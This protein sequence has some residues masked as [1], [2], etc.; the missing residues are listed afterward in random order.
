MS[1]NIRIRTNPD[2]SDSFVKLQLNQDFDF[3]EILSLKISQEDIYRSFY[4]DYGVVVGRVIMNSG[5]GVPNARISVFIPL[6]DEDAEDPELSSLYPYSDLQD[7]NS[8]GVR[9]N[10]LP[11]DSQGVCHAPIG[12]FPTKRELIDNDP[13]LEMYDKYFKYTTTTNGAGDFMLF[14]VPVGNHMINIDVDLSDIGIFSQRPY[15]FI[16]E[17]NPKKLFDSPTKFKTGTNLNNLTQ[18]K[19][20]Q[21]GVNVIPFWGDK[22]SNEIGISRIDVDLNY[23][24]NPKAIFMGS[25]FGDNEKNSV[26]KN[27]RPRKKTGKVCEMGQGEGSIQMLRKTIFGDNERYDVEGGRVIT[28][29]GTWAYQIPMNLDYMVTDEFGNLTPTDDPTKGIP[30]RSR[31]RFKINM[32]ST[33]GEGRLRTRAKYLVPHNPE[34]PDE[35]DYSFDDSTSDIQFRDLHWNKIYTVRNHIA[36]FQKD[37]RYEN[38]NFI[39]FKDVDDCVGDKNPIPFSKM[40]TDFNPVYT[41]LCLILSIILS[42]MSIVNKILKVEILSRRICRILVVNCLSITCP[43]NGFEYSPGCHSECGG[44]GNNNYQNAIDCFKIALASA[45]NVFEFDFYNDWINGSLYSFLFKYKKPKNSDPK[46]CGDGNGDTNN[47]IINTNPPNPDP[48]D[49]SPNSTIETSQEFQIDEGVIVSYEEELFYK[50]FSNSYNKLYSTDLYNLGAVFDCD[51][52]KKPKI[53]ES[54]IGT[55]YQLPPLTEDGDGD[56][57]NNVSHILN[58]LFGLTCIKV[59]ANS[60]QSQN[61]RRI[62]EIGVGLDEYEIND[63]DDEFDDVVNDGVIDNAD[64]DNELLR[65][66]LIKL[67]DPN[68]YDTN[69]D[70]IDSGFEGAEYNSYREQRQEAGITQFFGNSFYFYFGTQP[71]NSAIELMNSKYFTDCSRNIKNKLIIF[72]NVTNVTTVGGLNGSID[73]T[74]TGGV[75]E[76]TFAWYDSNDVL[77]GDEQNISGLMEGVYYVIV[78]DNNGDGVSGK[79]TFIINGL[80][81]LAANV[82]IRNISTDGATDGQIIF[83]SITGGVGPYDI[84]ITGPVSLSFN[85]IPYSITINDLG[86]GTYTII[87]TDSNIPTESTDPIVVTIGVPDNLNVINFQALNPNCIEFE[88]GIISFNVIG[89]TLDYNVQL[90]DSL[91]GTYAYIED[92]ETN[93]FSFEN[94]IPETYVLNITDA[95]GQE[96]IDE[97]ILLEEPEEL[98]LSN[99]GNVLTLYSYKVLNAVDGV[100]YDLVDGGEVVID[101]FPGDGGDIERSVL[102]LIG[103]L[104]DHQILSEFGCTSNIL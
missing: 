8:D 17:G 83:N 31:V 63:P 15:D 51:W 62:C 33:G 93:E 14:G 87:V 64:I 57:T 56:P 37:Q 74:V 52:Q 92:T 36:R 45:L 49:P 79:K 58:L 21:V 43:T 6:T 1:N 76:Y 101:S 70:N 73:I 78:T 75:P 59:E 88:D 27:C 42:I 103:D 34:T 3:L 22:L 38:R 81:S 25:I 69:I 60:R 104:S 16:E 71:N 18:I 86:A 32:D 13:I 100:M 10:T 50:P 24:I 67:N 94:L 65:D 89:G 97:G 68:F 46:F 98:I 53:Q 20:R 55:T 19:N 91:G 54:L 84:E 2:G 41:V 44:G 23:N 77:I 66:N 85:N 61:I 47:Y 26:N 82:S 99:E 39:G 11:K 95:F 35:V 5:V 28:D 40:D 29:K 4:S 72:G 90:T 80:Q 12:T 102:I 30:T 96:F 48:L 9:Y 7:L